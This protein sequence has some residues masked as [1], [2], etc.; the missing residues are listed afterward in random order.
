MDIEVTE[1]SIATS[2]TEGISIEGETQTELEGERTGEEVT[3]GNVVVD[4][5]P[6]KLLLLLYAIYPI[7]L[8]M[9][10]HKLNSILFHPQF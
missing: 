10:F 6:G 4:V 5:T 3:D 2:T 8:I 7:L 9:L 1:G